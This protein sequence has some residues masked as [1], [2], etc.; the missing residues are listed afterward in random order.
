MKSHASLLFLAVTFLPLPAA[1][2]APV[3]GQ[4]GKLLLEEKFEGDAVPKAWTKNFGALSLSGGALRAGQQASDQHAAAFRRA[5]PLRDCAIQVDF[6]FAGA[7]T[8]HLGFDPAPGE[9]K[10]SGH[11]FSLVVTPGQWSIM[12]HVDK[13]DPKSKNAVHAKAAV[14]FPRDTWHTLLLEV[15]GND[16]VARVDGREALRASAKDFHVKKPGLVFRVMGKDG[17]AMLFDN[18]RVWELK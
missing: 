2:L 16:V 1:D 9:L 6:K 10:K 13:S 5:L 17:D 4:K 14:K 8:F 15:K 18:V 3:L 11:L 12:E 7:T